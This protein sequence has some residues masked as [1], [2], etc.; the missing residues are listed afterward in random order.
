MENEDKKVFEV[1]VPVVL[2]FDVTVE[3]ESEEEAMEIARDEV[4]WEP[5]TNYSEKI[6]PI[7]VE[8]EEGTLN[9]EV[10]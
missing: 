1:Q 7:R 5:V 4:Y 2:L 3:A 9:L 10:L 6:L 8:T